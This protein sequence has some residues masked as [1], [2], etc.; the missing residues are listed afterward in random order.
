M[1]RAI[2]RWLGAVLLLAL[3]AGGALA[4]SAANA[5]PAT[6]FLR[7]EAG[8]HVAPVT[9]IVATS[10]GQ[11]LVTVSSD[12]TARVWAADGTLLRT[13]R[14]PIAEGDEGAL[15][16]AAMSPDGT[17][18]AVAGQTGAAWDTQALIYL[19][20]LETGRMIRVPT[21]VPARITA[22]TFAS[23][24]ERLG[25][26]FTGQAGVALIDFQSREI[27][28]PPPA[29]ITGGVRG[30]AFDGDGNLAVGSG[31]GLVHLLDPQLKPLKKHLLA[32]GATP[33]DLAISPDG[34]LL[35]VGIANMPQVRLLDARTLQPRPALPAAK[36][37]GTE[38]QHLRSVAWIAGS[39]GPVLVAGG[40]VHAPDGQSAVLR[41]PA[42]NAPPTVTGLGGTDAILR[43]TPLPG[44]RLAFAAADPAWGILGADGRPA[45]RLGG[46]GADF[47]GI[48]RGLTSVAFDQTEFAPPRLAATA[49]FRVSAD[50][51]VVE[52]GMA[53]GGGAVHRF[54]AASRRLEPL[55]G[56]PLAAAPVPGTLPLREW[57]NGRT[58]R[59]GERRLVLGEQ[60]RSLSAALLP[61]G[62]GFLLGTD[63]HLRRYAPDGTQI[64]EAV[65]PAAVWGVLPSGN[66]NV[67]VVALGDGTLRWLD[68]AGDAML[69]ERAALFPHRDGRRWILWTPE[70]FF[71][72]S[73]DGGQ[74]LAGFQ[75][76]RG[77][78][79]AAEWITFAQLYRSFYAQGLVQAR[80]ATGN[81][82]PMRERLAAMG[83]VRQL[84][85]NSPPPTL[86]IRAVC[87]DAP[88]STTET[89][90]EPGA[91]GS[92]SRGLGRL[93][94]TATSA[95]AP[96]GQGLA[97]PA[98]IERVRLRVEVQDGGGG[99]GQIDLFLNGR[100]I[101]RTADSRGLGRIAVGTPMTGGAPSPL[102]D[103]VQTGLRAYDRVV[104]LDPGPN[105]IQVRAFDA[106]NTGFRS[107]EVLEL[108]AARR[109]EPRRPVLHVLAAG[110]DD[111][112]M[113]EEAGARSLDNAVRDADA[114]VRLL[115]ERHATDYGRV[116]AIILK[117]AEATAAGIEAAFIRLKD[118]VDPA[119][120]LLVYLAGHGVS[121]GNRYVFLSFQPEKTDIEGALA[122][123]LDD[124]KLI[125]LWSALPARNSV[126]L[127]DTCYSRSF[128]LD[129]AGAV[130]NE[131]GRYVLAA[132]SEQAA[133]ATR[134]G[135]HGPFNVAVQ[136]ALRGEVERRPSG[137][138][139]QFTLGFHVRERVP[140]L[141][142]EVRLNQRAAFRMS[143]GDVPLPFSLTRMGP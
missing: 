133:D 111:Y 9:G 114:F 96:G 40:Y 74:D 116:N 69:R 30:I 121:E 63:T 11:R 130:Q 100:N 45:L 83:D 92:A 23:R 107:S 38:R 52:F 26:G 66:G 47:R 80:L 142:R 70:G 20:S 106:A 35:A 139:D 132:A 128:T 64:A 138:T 18:V 120:T 131:T 57:L 76:N 143:S 56:P 79:E 49:G 118:V 65:M 44:G 29:I 33:G 141:A 46:T 78:R 60:E 117:D 124:R 48:A 104:F 28:R 16:A 103:A 37:L 4:Q 5:P 17:H 55:S 108:T 54:N 88:G 77:P 129:F 110:I 73:D 93:R 125:A 43:L 59:L 41:W 19:F 123:G 89:C 109:P 84:L 2:R 53:R 137:A 91:A 10:D 8:M 102:G 7:I 24:G 136:E 86:S 22:L 112:R 6:P 135:Q 25:I 87:Y 99:I 15:T 98:G 97:L 134:G 67:A 51:M 115:R 94:E 81:D 32:E 61:G 39:G 21:R 42:L 1:T 36:A 105:A 68:L 71:D 58:P 127:L 90:E 122:R 85:R 3:T 119:D 72:H 31:D 82:A 140:V 113:T 34:S 95:A 75:L 62:A 50:G 13:F 12:K 14:P 126:L 27:L 101:G